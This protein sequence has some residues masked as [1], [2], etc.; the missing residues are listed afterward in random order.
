[1]KRTDDITRSMRKEDVDRKWLLVDASGK[2]VGR[3]SSQIA[4]LLRGKHKP[5]FTPHVDCGDF[6]VVINADKVVMTGKRMEQQ[7]YF[8]YTGYPGGG[9]H[10]SFKLLMEKKPEKI[11]WHSVRRMLPKNR[12]GRKMLKKLK[13]Y[14]GDQHPHQAQKPEAHEVEA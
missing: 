14:K 8:H 12:L 3:L 6:V 13:V 11:V 5:W 7:Q 1:M 9:R 4:H 10:E 2:T